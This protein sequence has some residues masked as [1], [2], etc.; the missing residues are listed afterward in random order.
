VTAVRTSPQREHDV[1]IA[2]NPKQCALS[3]S[4]QVWRFSYRQEARFPGPSEAIV[5][6]EPVA[7]GRIV[8]RA[9]VTFVDGEPVTESCRWTFKGLP[10]GEYVAFLL[11]PDGS[12]GAARFVLPNDQ[13]IVTVPPPQV[14]A[15]GTVTRGG[16]PA[17]RVMFRIAPVRFSRPAIL[18]VTDPGG[19]FSV[20]LDVPGAYE[21]SDAN[22]ATTRLTPWV[23]QFSV[24]AGENQ[25][26][27]EIPSN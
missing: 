5:I 2:G 15:S 1:T 23:R 10:D 4:V 16:V 26:A 25:V 13:A 9:F 18:V 3:A 7:R 14:V 20:S 24:H 6:S 19:K 11:R 27:L 17:G 12:G 22:G 8:A 21:A